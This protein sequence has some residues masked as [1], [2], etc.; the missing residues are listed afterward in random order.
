MTPSDIHLTSSLSC[1][2]DCVD[3]VVTLSARP[4]NFQ[5]PDSEIGGRNRRPFVGHNRFTRKGDSDAHATKL[6]RTI[7]Y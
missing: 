6:S 2:E 5:P 7:R 3:L 4:R 1:D